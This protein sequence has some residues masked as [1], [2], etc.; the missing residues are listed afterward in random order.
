MSESFANASV[1]VL[2]PGQQCLAWGDPLGVQVARNSLP[3]AP[4]DQKLR[5]QHD[6][7]RSRASVFDPYELIAC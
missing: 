1:P 7:K 3:D 4:E 5:Q 6:S 2:P